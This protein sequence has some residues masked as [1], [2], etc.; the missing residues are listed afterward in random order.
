MVTR[1]GIR[2]IP[3]QFGGPD[4]AVLRFS[5][6]DKWE[7]IVSVRTNQGTFNDYFRNPFGITTIAQP[8]IAPSTQVSNS[9]MFYVS[10]LDQATTLKVQ[11][12]NVVQGDQGTEYVLNTTLAADDTSRADGFIYAANRFSMPMGLTYQFASTEYLFVVDADKDSV[13]KFTRTGLEGVQPLPGASRRKPIIVSFGGRGNGPKQF[14]RP[15]A[16]ANVGRTLYVCDAGN[17]RI[18][19]YRLTRDME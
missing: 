6:D 13:Y 12:I 10:M 19:R 9:K 3:N 8:P 17:G 2:N 14:N 7:G 16:V 5:D 11:A 18:M 15:V 4:N 1:S